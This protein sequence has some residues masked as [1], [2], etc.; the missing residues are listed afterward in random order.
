[1]GHKDGT[2]PPSNPMPKHPH[3]LNRDGRYYYR[4]RIPLDLVR[5]GCY[6]KKKEIKR[7]LK[8]S[9]LSTA[10]SR[11]ITMAL[12]I[13]EEF[14]AKRHEFIK[15]RKNARPC[16][17]E[18]R[19]FSEIPEIER[20][21]FIMRYFIAMELRASELRLESDPD[22]RDE[23]LYTVKQD[24][25]VYDGDLTDPQCNWIIQLRKALEADGIS[26]EDA[27][28][29]P[30]SDLARKMQRAT[31]EAT[32][33]TEHA[34]RGEPFETFDPLFAGVHADSPLPSRAKVSKTVGD[35]CGEYLVHVENRVEKGQLAPSMISKIKM[36]C[37]IMADF[38]DKSK[39]LASIT[40]DDAARLV[41]F[42]PT[43]PVN[44]AKRYK[45]ISLV[46][47]AEREGRLDA[48][49]LIHPK[50]VD[51]YF[52]GLS[53]ML[54]HAVDLGWLE[55]NPLKG[56]LIRERLP[57]VVRR[58]RKTLTPEEM[59]RVFSLPD[60]LKQKDGKRPARFWVPLLCVFHGTRA[61]E[62]AA[63]RVVDVKEEA[64]I[65]FLNLR[66]TDGHRLKT[67]SSTRLVPLHQR[68]IDMGF[69]EFVAKRREEDPE[70]YLFPGLSRNDNGSM[71]DGVCKWWA[72][73]VK[74]TLGVSTS[75]GASGAR[76]MHSLRHSWT[77]AARSAG[78]S[79]STYKR[80][81]GWSQ[82]D[83]SEHYGSRLDELPMLKA[84]IDKIKFP[85]VK[86]P[87]ARRIK[88]K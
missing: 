38:F 9:D 28:A 46:K 44:A 50:T 34:L 72:R 74:A 49:R 5:T 80:L 37:L 82:P 52:T 87:G 2:Q 65:S 79:K 67:A 81:G 25:A 48:K 85:G 15:P 68:V 40:R 8:T 31:V 71:A 56:R 77:T 59:T 23:L 78:L 69:L 58:E 73:L 21:N 45:G 51:D 54:S 30:L 33:R 41:D 66:E 29:V 36:R 4:K 19:R 26:T 57:K 76:G 1:M 88:R 61:N 7:T 10:N 22:I 42:L 86:F 16:K 35:L 11:A 13:D 18:K 6:G 12:Q 60:F 84:E 47:A 70:G 17:S 55:A 53:A 14:R 62:V 24:L 63:M 43:I 3:I 83:A 20:S 64:K 75:G 39:P 27:D 32:A